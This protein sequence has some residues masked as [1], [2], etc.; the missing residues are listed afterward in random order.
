MARHGD[1]GEADRQ[2][3]I[4]HNDIG[5]RAR[6]VRWRL[7]RQGEPAVEGA[8]SAPL[9][10]DVKIQETCDGASVRNDRGP[11]D[12]GAGQLRLRDALRSRRSDGRAVF[13]QQAPCRRVCLKPPARYLQGRGE[14]VR[15]R[16]WVNG[17][18]HNV[19]EGLPPRSAAGRHLD[20]RRPLRRVA[21]GDVCAAGAASEEGGCQ[22]TPGCRLA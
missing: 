15:E 1:A 4:R 10:E 14:A 16:P 20:R 9:E 8:R 7:Q 6:D 3:G 17:S 22:G 18:D 13:E 21:L 12:D 11:N 5:T 2:R 19:G